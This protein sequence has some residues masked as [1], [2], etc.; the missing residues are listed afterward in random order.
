MK[1]GSTFSYL[2]T[3][4]ALGQGVLGAHAAP[5]ILATGAVVGIGYLA[6]TYLQD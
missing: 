2:Q 5:I 4:G 1:A 3:F 6:Y